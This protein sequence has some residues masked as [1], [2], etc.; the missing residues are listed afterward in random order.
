M[1][2]NCLVWSASPFATLIPLPQ[3]LST[4]WMKVRAIAAVA[5]ATSLSGSGTKITTRTA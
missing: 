3:P 5:R 1:A 4:D 2:N